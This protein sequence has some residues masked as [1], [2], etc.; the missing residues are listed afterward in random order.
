VIHDITQRRQLEEQL[1]QAQKMEAVGRLAG[2]VAHDFNNLLM[3]IKG[4]SEMMLER[5]GATER[6]RKN[7]GE[8]DKA[9]D[10][11]A[12]LTRQLLAFSRMQV[13]QPKI[14]DLNLVVDEMAR[15]LGPLIGDHIELNIVS[16]A[17]LGAVKADQ[18]QI[19]QVL[20]NLVINGR[21]A[22]PKGGILTIEIAN[23][24]L[25]QAH[26]CQH[27]EMRPGNY[28]MMAVSDTGLGMEAETQTHIFEPFFTT[29][30]LGKGTG[31]GLAT[32]YGAV[33]QNGGWIWVYSEPGRGTT[34]K[35]YLPQVEQVVDAPDQGRVDGPPLHG[36]ETIL[37][38]EDQDAIR[39]VAREFLKSSGYTILEARDGI[40]AL[41]VAQEHHGDIDLLLTDV[42][43]PRMGG[44]ELAIRLANL[45]P[46]MKAIYMSG[47]TEFA[48]DNRK[49]AESEKAILQKPF[50]LV[51]L[52][53]KVREVL[54]V[55]GRVA[56]LPK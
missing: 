15:M 2:G 50:A 17:S 11:A 3:I 34:F 43:M 7:A 56:L 9:A 48:K 47:Y 32:V 12:S 54:G 26:A 49:L 28:V 45:R 21:D 30:E 55:Q 39:D 31:L 51:T 42:V 6:S 37:L 22:M 46:Q 23:I 13:I 27:A 25:D 1:R 29:K 38:V 52:A 16:G 18:G 20:M 24:F 8:I 14:L 33:K 40:E 44:P 36:S 35:I 10:K 53:R 4:N 5:L 19:E 41:Q